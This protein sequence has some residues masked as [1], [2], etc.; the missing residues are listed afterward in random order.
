MKGSE[1][2]REA[3]LTALINASIPASEALKLIDE[4]ATEVVKEALQQK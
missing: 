1:S 4:F 2:P 3:L